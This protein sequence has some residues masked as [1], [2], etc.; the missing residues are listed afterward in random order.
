MKPFQSRLV[1]GAVAAAIALTASV[2]FAAIPSGGVISG[3]YTRSG[4]TLRVVDSSTTAC[5]SGETAIQWNQTGPAGP[6]GLVGPAGP[7][8][9]QGPD[10]AQGIPGQAGAAGPMGPQGVMG[11]AGPPGP[12]TEAFIGRNDTLTKINEPG[13]TLVALD[14]PAGQY[15][16]FG[17][18][19]IQNEDLDNP[20]LGD[21]RLSTGETTTVSLGALFDGGWR[22]SVS[23]QDLL[24]LSAA[25]RV[26]LLCV[27]PKGAARGAKLTAI[28]VGAL[29]G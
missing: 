29:H 24:T 19:A 26:S 5:R 20:N 22:Q 14:L 27:T 17:K 18:A 11:A 8:G 13:T 2:A 7:L 9:P 1:A 15:A 6:Q 10:G 23:V 16:I 25:G 4:G 28:K 12:G 3:C 21:C